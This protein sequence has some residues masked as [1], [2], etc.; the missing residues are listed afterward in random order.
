MFLCLL[1]Y[2][3]NLEIWVYL[4]FDAVMI[5]IFSAVSWIFYIYIK[6]DK[7]SIFYV[8]VRICG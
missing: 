3:V 2:L 1:L 5:M 6:V 8:F 4:S 7:F